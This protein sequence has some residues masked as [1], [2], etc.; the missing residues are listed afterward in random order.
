MTRMNCLTLLTADQ[1]SGTDGSSIQPAV[2][3]A[4]VRTYD[5]MRRE[6]FCRV[7]KF[8]VIQS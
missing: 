8:L 5:A 3:M 4:E 7:P 6:N 1:S 2:G